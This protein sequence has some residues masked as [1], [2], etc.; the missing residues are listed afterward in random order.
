MSAHLAVLVLSTT[1]GVL[2]VIVL[3]RS[4]QEGERRTRTVDPGLPWRAG[5][6]ILA[7]SIVVGGSGWLLPALVVGAMVWHGVGR[8]QRRDRGRVDDIERTDALA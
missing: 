3:L 5:A 4:G 8:W 7:A 6:G 1:I 2:A